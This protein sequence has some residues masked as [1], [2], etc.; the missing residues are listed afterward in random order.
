M[1]TLRNLK[2]DCFWVLKSNRI[3]KLNRHK[4]QPLITLLVKKLLLFSYLQYF[5]II[6]FVLPVS[7][8]SAWN[9]SFVLTLAFCITNPISLITRNFKILKNENKCLLCFIKK[10]LINFISFKCTVLHYLSSYKYIFNVQKLD[11]F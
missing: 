3:R 2:T 7:T 9:S 8:I 11:S 4:H 5:K 1:N 10:H 6:P